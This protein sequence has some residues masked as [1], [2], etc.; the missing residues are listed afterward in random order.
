MIVGKVTE[1]ARVLFVSLGSAKLLRTG[2]RP[3][4]VI[5]ESGNGQE[6]TVGQ[7]IS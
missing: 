6:I 5:T 4:K 7:V 1:Q 2:P 3:V